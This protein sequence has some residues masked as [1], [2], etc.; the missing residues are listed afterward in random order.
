MCLGTLGRIKKPLGSL[1]C[2]STRLGSLQDRMI[3]GEAGEV[4]VEL[5]KRP[6]AMSRAVR[7]GSRLGPST[8]LGADVL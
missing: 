5:E 6:E 7:Y 8:G 3:T 2:E 4:E 1:Y